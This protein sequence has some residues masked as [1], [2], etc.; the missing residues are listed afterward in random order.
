M[1]KRSQHFAADESYHLPVK[2]VPLIL[3]CGGLALAAHAQETKPAVSTN[4]S[5]LAAEFSFE[6][7]Q[8][9][10][11]PSGWSGGP[12]GTVFADDKIVHGGRWA[13]RIERNA[14]S[15]ASASVLTKSIPIN[16]SG[17]SIELRGFLRTEDVSDFAGLW[18]REDGESSGLAFDNMQSRQLKGTTN[19][20]EYSITLPL[21]SEARQLFF[22]ALV[23]GTGKVWADDFQLLVDGKPVWAV[24][25]IEKPKTAIDLDHQFDGGSGIAM[26]Q[27]TPMQIENL[28]TLGKV[29]GFLKYHHPQ[30]TSGQR[31]WDYD[32]FRILPTVLAAQDRPTA[33][34][35]LLHWVENLGTVMPCKPC[36]KLEE[37]DLDFHPDLDWITNPA[38]QGADLSAGLLAIRGNRVP[39]KQFYVSKV[40]KVGNPEFDHE[41]GYE[42]LKFPDAGFQLLALYRFWN[43]IEYWSPD[44]DIVGE[45]WN[46]VLTEFIPKM[47]LARSAEAYQLE[48]MTLVAKAH[49]GH[50]NLWGN[51][52]VRPPVGECQLPVIVRFVENLPVIAGFTTDSNN[53]AGV[54]LGDVI[55]ELDG[56]AVAKLVVDRL[57]Y[58]AASND[59]ARMRDIA[60]YLTR[61][62]CRESSI[63]VS[64]DG[65]EINF[66]IGRVPYVKADTTVMT[67]DLPGPTFRL[68]SK[69][70]AYLKLS[71]VKKADSAQYIAQ[72]AR[73][74]GL[75]VD[76]RNYPSEFVVFALGSHFIEKETEFVRFTE[77]DLSNPGAFHWGKSQSLSPEKPHYPGKIVVLVDEWSMSQAEYTS[78][79]FRSAP[80]AVVVGSTT[81]GAD[82]DVSPF[83]LPGGLHTMISGLGVFYPDKSPT[84]RI[85]IVP[86]VEVRPTI[87]G[88]R[89]GRDEVLEEGLRQI[90]GHDIPTAEIEKIAKP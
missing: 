40:A 59:T 10:G 54:K 32:L 55:T 35:A 29:W 43:I 22:G 63:K 84:Q 4:P 50:A 1:R 46:N 72:A 45:D 36:A 87:A 83:M 58:Y 65:Q 34:A 37:S 52:D 41:L 64:R 89:N 20:T 68:L 85:G 27:L 73:T 6:T 80:G 49:D 47:A 88:I 3:I 44:R 53:L 82:G 8:T 48:L 77:A 7:P 79:A 30:I 12:A 61:G 76:I 56:V 69:N 2:Q 14:D 71:S 13:A 31:H 74:K 18:M 60:R 86:N 21:K 33:N 57:P 5:D 26:N 19:W 42:N 90:L 78:M 39:P 62:A 75:I 38:L 66:K 15:P 16:F 11:M 24:P 23:V 67:H 70:V 25:K 51:L 81:A 17:T 28:A 9:G